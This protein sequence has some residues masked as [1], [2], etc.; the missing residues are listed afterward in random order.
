MI[1][2]KKIECRSKTRKMVSTVESNKL[3]YRW[4]FLILTLTVLAFLTCTGHQ[5]TTLR[6]VTVRLGESIQQA[7]EQAPWGG[8]I[9][10]EPGTYRESLVIDKTIHLKG[11]GEGAQDVKICAQNNGYSVIQIIGSKMQYITLSNLNISSGTK[12]GCVSGIDIQGIAWVEIR[13]CDIINFTEQGICLS[14]SSYLSFF[15]S[16]ISEIGHPMEAA[17][18]DHEDGSVWPE[19]QWYGVVAKDSSEIRM[20]Q[21]SISECWRSGVAG[22]DTVKI[23]FVD[24]HLTQ[25]AIGIELRGSAEIS[26]EGTLCAYNALGVL[27]WESSTVLIEDCRVLDC[28]HSLVVGGEAS[29]TVRA[30]AVVL[31]TSGT[32][33]SQTGFEGGKDD[34]TLLEEDEEGTY[35]YI[36]V[37]AYGSSQLILDDCFFV[38]SGDIGIR[39]FD[40]SLGFIT[41][42]CVI[43]K[44][45][46]LYL[47]QTAQ[48]TVE[49]SFFERNSVSAVT[50][51]HTACLEVETSFI[52]ENTGFGIAAIGNA[53]LSFTDC[54]VADNGYHGALLFDSAELT[55][56]NSTF[57]AN[58][59]SGILLTGDGKL[60]INGTRLYGNEGFGIC[61]ML[62]E[63]PGEYTEEHVFTGE[64]QGSGNLISQANDP[65]GNRLGG[66]CPAEIRTLITGE[67]LEETATRDVDVVDIRGGDSIQDAIDQATA[68]TIL[69]L[70][71]GTYHENLVIS[72]NLTFRGRGASPAAVKIIGTGKSQPVIMLNS[73]ATIEVCI[74]GI[75]ISG[76]RGEE[77]GCGLLAGDVALTLVNCQIQDNQS[78]GI[79]AAGSDHLSVIHCTIYNNGL[80]G[81]GLG[82]DLDVCVEYSSISAN[83]LCGISC[84]E[85]VSARIISCNISNNEIAGILTRGETTVTIS[86]SAVYGNKQIGLY[87][88]DSSEG[89]VTFSSIIANYEN[90][91]EA[92]DD[93]TLT[94]SFSSVTENG[95]EGIFL[96]NSAEL[97]LFYSFINNNKED[98]IGLMGNPAAILENSSVSENDNQGILLT[99]MG[100]VD[101]FTCVVSG[102]TR[103]GIWVDDS[104]QLLSQ[105]SEISYNQFGVVGTRLAQIDLQNCDISNNRA[106][107]LMLGGHA[108]VTLMECSLT[109]NDGYGIWLYTRDCVSETDYKSLI[110]FV[111]SL[112]GHSNILVAN[113]EGDLCPSCSSS[114]WPEGFW[115]E[116]ETTPDSSKAKE[117][118][119]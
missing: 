95:W 118:T 99:E 64:I 12:E 114:L 52:V 56:R 86:D 102:N 14:G 82:G 33:K 16:T 72:K 109:E 50:A 40:S 73:T 10:I 5:D 49:N 15:D 89:T 54:I 28:Q 39:L 3:F 11:V 107:G 2:K 27:A 47:S 98:G 119:P 46:G 87:F 65:D 91:V 1:R 84:E 92:S 115:A 113:A 116:L 104:A 69:R 32:P 110:E 70:A 23:V 117:R 74:E 57:S 90:G 22:Y 101:M 43:K 106:D 83:N 8:V 42:C 35:T 36:G 76:G 13:Q 20:E 103:S 26:I 19:T 53:K 79:L 85:S 30:S 25:N 7:I 38:G 41:N 4:I 45:Y 61:S 9:C 94:V 75:T 51:G 34:F 77:K 71:P 55:I 67:N 58:S 63:C 108:D 66:V 60:D 93:T 59:G 37:A 88:A 68:G 96:A 100:R 48:A 111:G 62:Y 17:E 6:P 97:S 21:A 24:G 112:C 31:T 18:V 78:F 105:R 80:S 29:M 81:F 44:S